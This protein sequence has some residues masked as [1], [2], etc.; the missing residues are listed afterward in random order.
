LSIEHWID[1][2]IVLDMQI[3]RLDEQRF[4]DELDRSVT[5]NLD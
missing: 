1:P 5:V 3:W 4:R 2:T